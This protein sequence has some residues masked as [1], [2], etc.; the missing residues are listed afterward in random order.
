MAE[1]DG[2]MKFEKMQPKIYLPK[3]W[4]RKMGIYESNPNIA[5]YFDG[6]KITIERPVDEDGVKRAPLASKQRIHRFAM[7]W[8]EMYKHHSTIPYYYFED[9]Y[10]LGEEFF[11]LGFVMDCGESLRKALP[12]AEDFF[13]N[14]EE[15]KMYLGKLDIQTLGNA[16]FSQWRYFNHWAYCPM[17]EKDFEWFVIALTRLAE[18][19]E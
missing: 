19:T 9:G 8:L 7:I 5:M 11:S 3:S 18:L 10:M 14:N 12:Q 17:Q 6:R 4:V 1:M 16:I 13:N 15:L 2:I